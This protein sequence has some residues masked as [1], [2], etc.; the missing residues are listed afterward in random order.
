MAAQTT[1]PLPHG[2]H[3]ADYVIDRRIG[4]GGFSL[5]YLAFD[6]D[7]QPV[8]I[9]EYLPGGIVKRGELGTL[10]VKITAEYKPNWIGVTQAALRQFAGDNK[11]V[12]APVK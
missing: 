6:I 8:A 12:K 7:G 1:E 5:V 9:K 3:L 4:G 10:I 2:Y 11:E